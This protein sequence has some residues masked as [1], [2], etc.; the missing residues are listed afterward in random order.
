[1]KTI[2]TLIAATLLTSFAMGSANAL[3]V[4]DVTSSANVRVQVENGVATI[5]G[6]VESGF[7]KQLVAQQA[8]KIEGVERV[9]NLLTF[10][11]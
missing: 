2:K 4:Q 10:S 8:K 5:F 3:T 1:M 11:N 6:N 7:D 9:R